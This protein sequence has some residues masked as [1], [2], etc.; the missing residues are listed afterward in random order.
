MCFFLAEILFQVFD[1]RHIQTARG[2]F[3]ACCN[4]IK[5]GTNKGNIRLEPLFSLKINS[6][7]FLDQ[8]CKRQGIL[9]TNFNISEVH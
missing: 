5:Y 7:E 8:I 4:H 6:F 3:E 1:A 9:V 2:M